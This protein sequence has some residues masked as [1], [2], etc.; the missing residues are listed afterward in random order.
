MMFT[1]SNPAAAGRGLRAHRALLA[2]LV[3]A[4]LAGCMVGPDYVRPA[5]DHGAGFKATGWELADPSMASRPK[6]SWWEI[7]DDA[8]LDDLMR[9]VDVSNLNIAQAE[10]KYRQA[11]ALLAGATAPLMPTVS[12][13]GSANRT[14]GSAT[15]AVGVVS[16]TGMTTY[17][18]TGQVSWTIDIWGAVRRNMESQQANMDALAASIGGARLTAQSTL[19]LTY[20]QLRI[21]DERARVFAS[22]VASYERA[23]TLTQNKYEAGVVGM[24]D[25]AIARTQL[26]STR[27]QLIDT[28]QQRAVLENAIAVLLGVPPSQLSIAPAPFALKAPV[29]PVVL[30]ARLLQQRPDIASAERLTAA[31]NAQIGVATAA[32]FPS[33]TLNASGGYRSNDYLNWFAFPSQFWAL[34]PILAQTIFDGGARQALIDQNRA[35]FDGAVATYRLTVLQA[36]QQVENALVQLRVYEQEEKV[37]WEAVLSAREAVRLS[38]NQYDQGIVD[39]LSVAVL[40]NTA[41]NNEN[42]YLTLL[43]NR[44]AASVQLIVAL[45]GGWTVDDIRKLDRSG[46][47]VP[48]PGDPLTTE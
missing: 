23:L 48:D 5:V 3:S 26:Q 4:A 1:R 41:L 28:Q 36:L 39:Y 37:Q 17:G 30:P 25:V 16:S 2:C 40:E 35:L 27:A 38:K 45:G 47:Y 8:L 7:Y 34:G 29:V 42:S 31:A 46:K 32:W 21:V 12:A 15:S 9:R 33:L 14:G 44:L 43:G 6:G 18:A 11:I 19:A 20:M 24:G 13:S 22:A 10:A